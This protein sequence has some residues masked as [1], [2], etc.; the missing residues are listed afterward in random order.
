[1]AID[2]DGV[3]VGQDDMPI[4]MVRKL[5]GPS[6]ILG[7]SVG[8]PSEVETLAKWGPDMVDYIGVGTLF[9]YIN[10]EKS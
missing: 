9:P 5:L 8:K 10:K 4:P 2:A 1:M 3:H 7:W 6:K